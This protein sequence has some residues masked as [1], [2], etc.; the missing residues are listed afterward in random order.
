MPDPDKR[1][2]Q[3]PED[4]SSEGLLDKAHRYYDQ[5]AHLVE[6]KYDEMK[7]WLTSDE[8]DEVDETEELKQRQKRTTTGRKKGESQ[9]QGKRV[10]D[11]DE[12]DLPRAEK[13]VIQSGPAHKRQEQQQQELPPQKLPSQD[14]EKSLF[15]EQ[16]ERQQSGQGKEQVEAPEEEIH[17]QE[18]IHPIHPEEEEQQSESKPTTST[19]WHSE[20]ERKAIEKQEAAGKERSRFETAEQS[21]QGP[22][23]QEQEAHGEAKE[24]S[25]LRQQQR[26][27]K[28]EMQ[29]ELLQT[30]QQH[31]GDVEGTREMAPGKG[32]GRPS[33]KE[34]SPESTTD[35]FS[36]LTGR[37]P[38]KKQKDFE[39]HKAERER[40]VSIEAKPSP[41]QPDEED[42][43]EWEKHKHEQRAK[44]Q[45]AHVQ[46]KEFE[47]NP[48]TRF[49]DIGQKVEENV[50]QAKKDTE[51]HTKE[52]HKKLDEE[53]RQAKGAKPEIAQDTFSR[54]TNRTKEQKRRDLA[55]GEQREHHKL[56]RS[57]HAGGGRHP[58]GQT[59]LTPTAT[60]DKTTMT[61][62]HGVYPRENDPH[63][64][65]DTYSRLTGRSNFQKQ[66][67]MGIKQGREQRSQGSAELLHPEVLPQAAQHPAKKHE[68]RHR[69]KHNWHQEHESP[70]QEPE[71]SPEGESQQAGALQHG[72]LH[73]AKAS[74]QPTPRSKSEWQGY[75]QNQQQQQERA[76]SQRQHQEQQQPQ[77]QR[78]HHEHEWYSHG[79]ARQSLPPDH[80]L[81]G[82]WAPTKSETSPGRTLQQDQRQKEREKRLRHEQRRPIERQLRKDQEHMRQHD[83]QLQTE[84]GQHESGDLQWSSQD[85]KQWNPRT[86]RPLQEQQQQL[87]KAEHASWE[88]PQH[89]WRHSLE[90]TEN[91]GSKQQ[92]QE[93]QPHVEVQTP[94]EIHNKQFGP[95]ALHKHHDLQKVAPVSHPLPEHDQPHHQHSPREKS[96]HS[97][98]HTPLQ[99]HQQETKEVAEQ[100]GQSAR[101]VEKQIKGSMRDEAKAQQQDKETQEKEEGR[102]LPKS[103]RYKRVSEHSWLVA[104]KPHPHHPAGQ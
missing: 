13:E 37:T 98:V 100:A 5:A 4:T 99:S 55:Q 10:E 19:T 83:K 32:T 29:R 85:Y 66:K 47:K 93:N 96:G 59:E 75:L 30:Y 87:Y 79:I 50:E 21:H 44:Q 17:H 41:L 28:E 62:P 95:H 39:E 7:R 35:T 48:A 45:P 97:W 61:E 23:E 24:E 69:K 8:E 31:T 91:P 49:E 56:W 53:T 46:H 80:A 58:R 26:V 104:E 88:E 14:Q 94:R 74:E 43:G 64:T 15:E 71:Q 40:H 76:R 57:K 68:H 90:H 27:N 92:E 86:A 18:G 6:E 54:L 102:D 63:A 81:Q 9:R 16:L 25:R 33:L 60:V 38:E 89:Q 65:T 82:E 67:S 20:P 11:V 103:Q 2:T 22:Q 84:L 3:Q 12:G 101:E 78:P 36:H 1:T 52:I 73:Q 72:D 77:V 34:N 42:H 51:K 70:T